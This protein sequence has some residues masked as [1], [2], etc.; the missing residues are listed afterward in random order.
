MGIPQKNI[1]QPEIT[2]IRIDSFLGVNKATDGTTELKP[3]EARE[4]INFRVTEGYNLK[5]MEG[6]KAI[7]ESLGEGNIHSICEVNLNGTQM[8]VFNDEDIQSFL[9]CECDDDF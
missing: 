6:Y 8:V 1:V 5:K 7:F 9:S 2:P 4:C 3:G